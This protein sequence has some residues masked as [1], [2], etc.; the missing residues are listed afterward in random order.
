MKF[1]TLLLIVFGCLGTKTAL[2]EA[3]ID[4]DNGPLTG[5]YGFPDSREGSSLAGVG[6]DVWE[7]YVTA[8]SHST[9]DA[10]DG[11]S[12]LFDGETRRVG[13][14]Y[15]RG[16]S[17]RLELGMDVPWVSHESGGLDGFIERWHNIFGLPDGIRRERPRDELLFSYEDDNGG[18]RFARNADGP[19][20]ARLLGGW[21]LR[22]SGRSSSALRFS[23]KFPTGDSDSLLGSGGIDLSVGIAGDG[24]RIMGVGRLSGFYR[25]SAT[26]LGTPH[27]D[28]PPVRRVVGQVSAGLGYDLT[29][30]STLGLQFL[31]RSPVYDSAVSPLGDVAASLT[32]GVRFRLSHEY[33]LTLAVGEDIHPGSMPDVTFVL[34][35]RRR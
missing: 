32:A 25:A 23:V 6:D 5:L 7:F 2:A 27:F 29:T 33:A 16:V 10:N 22:Q 14:R 9:R 19:G 12:V 35:L 31:V 21:R 34:S 3:L 8:S 17:E 28:S 13:L 15:R 30:R 18:F 4:R 26:W 24:R 1:G 11:E 20:D